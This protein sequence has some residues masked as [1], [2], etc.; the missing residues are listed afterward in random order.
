MISISLKCFIQVC[1]GIETTLESSQYVD[2][3]QLPEAC[4][5]NPSSCENGGSFSLWVKLLNCS[6]GGI[7]TSDIKGKD[8]FKVFCKEEI[9]R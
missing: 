4:I 9:I 8:G 6:N 3:G 5:A 7:I 1:G 2:L